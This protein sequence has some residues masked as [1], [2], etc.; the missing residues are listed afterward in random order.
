MS[1]RRRNVFILLFV[2]LLAAASVWVLVSK[3]TQKGLDLQGGV[4]LV[5]QVSP[6]RGEPLTDDSIQR[7]I[8]VMQDRVNRYGVG[9]AEIQRSGDNQIVVSLP[10]ITNPEEARE[11]VGTTAQMAFYDWEANVVGPGGR[12]DPA[13][14]NVT[15]GQ[16]A[17]DK[18]SP[19]ALSQYDAVERASKLKPVA[20]G[21]PAP[22]LGDQYYLVDDKAKKVLSTEG[23]ESSIMTCRTT[24]RS[25][26]TSTRRR[27]SPPRASASSR[28]LRATAS[29]RP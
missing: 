27:R 26:S 17:A 23:P 8:D 28:C 3:P 7:T 9:E 21:K 29:S 16:F 13:D 4:Q 18:T 10:S 19:A 25:R 5:Y 15:G 1:D 14:Q 2:A 6:T 24:A 11:R 12:I 20:G 22:V